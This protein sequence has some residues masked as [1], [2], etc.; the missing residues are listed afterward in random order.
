MFWAKRKPK[1][2]EDATPTQEVAQLGNVIRQNHIAYV[3]APDWSGVP[4]VGA[5]NLAYAPDVLLSAP[6]FFGGNAVLR[7][8]NAITIANR[9]AFVNAAK[10]VLD[11]VGGVTA[12]QIIGQPLLEMDLNLTT[13]E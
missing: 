13:P 10:Q 6:E 5:A 9:P 7:T 8:P 11:G 2:P 12:G 1:P 3:P 4:G